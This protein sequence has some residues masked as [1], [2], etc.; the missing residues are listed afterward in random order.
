MDSNS[1]NAFLMGFSW[2]SVL[3]RR[4]P[5][6]RTG[7][8]FSGRG[9]PKLFVDSSAIQPGMAQPLEVTR[10]TA[11][12]MRPRQAHQFFKILAGDD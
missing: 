10:P 5:Q 2:T 4:R 3:L 6:K 7:W 12:I 1:K 8:S 11:A 9:I